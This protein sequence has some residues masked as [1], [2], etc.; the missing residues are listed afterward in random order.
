MIFL[1]N[2]LKKF[3]RALLLGKTTVVTF[4]FIQFWSMNMFALILSEHLLCAHAELGWSIQRRAGPS[5]SSV[6]TGKSVEGYRSFYS[7][8]RVENG[9][10][11]ATL[12]DSAEL[13]QVKV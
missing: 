13:V 5:S 9:V 8:P 11:G 7:S 1:Q 4:S 3:L 12:R 10:K 2:N 6:T